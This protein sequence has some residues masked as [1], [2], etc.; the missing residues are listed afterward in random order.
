MFLEVVIQLILLPEVQAGLRVH[1]I[2]PGVHIVV[3]PLIV[4]HLH[5]VARQAV[6]AVVVRTQG[7]VQVAAA[8]VPVVRAEA[9]QVVEV[10]DN[11]N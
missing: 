5:I 8:V 10:E 7:V 2:L 9:V 6:Q 4:V 1:Q 3:H 11:F